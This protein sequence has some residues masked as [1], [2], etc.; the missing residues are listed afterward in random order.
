MQKVIDKQKYYESLGIDIATASILAFIDGRIHYSLQ[1]AV[2]KIANTQAQQAHPT[3]TFFEN[4][5][6]VVP[7]IEIGIGSV[8]MAFAPNVGST[9]FVT[10]FALLGYYGYQEYNDIKQLIKNVET[11]V[12]SNA[13]FKA[14]YNDLMIKSTLKVNYGQFVIPGLLTLFGLLIM[15]AN[16]ATGI[17][18]F[19]VGLIWLAKI[20]YDLLKQLPELA[21]VAKILNVNV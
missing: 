17:I 11:K 15:N 10:S 9:I 19:L 20:V 3:L 6:F 4:D 16:K 5:F 1:N 2:G 14:L 8:I 7:I 12:E 13:F 18:I 21:Q